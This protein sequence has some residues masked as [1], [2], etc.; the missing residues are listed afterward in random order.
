MRDATPQAIQLHDY[1]PPAF[2]ISQVH[3]DVDIGDRE[4][5]VRSTLHVARN[6]EAKRPDAPLV[7]D[8]EG[9]ELL[10]AAIDGR[11]LDEGDYRLD[12]THLTIPGVADAFTLQTV[13]RFDPWKNTRLEGLYAT[14][15]GLVTQCEA[16]G[17]RRITFFIDR[18]DVM[19]RYVVAI[20]AERARFPRLLA[21]GNLLEEG[22]GVPP[23]WFSAPKEGGGARHWARWD[24]PFAKP[25]YLFA[26]VA[27][28]LDLLEEHFATR[29]GKDALLQIYVERGKLDHAGFAMQALKKCMRW[30]EERFGLELDLER[31]MIV[32]VS[33]FNAGAMENKGL[34]IFNTKYILARA[35]TATDADYFAVDKVIAHE[36]FHNWTGNRVTCR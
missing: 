3:L 22:E 15:S 24:D 36:Y 30:D 9:L 2:R 12:A 32:A 23:G 14:A 34:N 25:S 11:T 27:A 10:S 6:A 8:G 29:S 16:Q 1:L 13:V 5:T 35:D 17:F 26:L 33:D 7:L 31:F 21:N 19:A 20:C 18:P 28:N 4:V